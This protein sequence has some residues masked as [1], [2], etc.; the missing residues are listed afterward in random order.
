MGD[1]PMNSMNVGHFLLNV[2]WHIA[3]HYKWKTEMSGGVTEDV[4]TKLPSPNNTVP[5]RHGE[6]TPDAIW[7]TSHTKTK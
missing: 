6:N 5:S 3:Q 1:M 7:Y 4:W 2:M